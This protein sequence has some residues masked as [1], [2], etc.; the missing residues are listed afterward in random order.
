MPASNGVLHSTRWNS[1]PLDTI[2]CMP[3]VWP[4]AY[5]PWRVRSRLDLDR[6]RFSPDG[7]QRV[8]P[9][10][11]QSEFATAKFTA[12]KTYSGRDAKAALVL[13][14][15]NKTNPTALIGKAVEMLRTH[16]Q[17]VSDDATA[18]TNA[19]HNFIMSHPGDPDIRLALAF[20]PVVLTSSASQQF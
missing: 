12:E 9:R 7:Q 11:L 1:S 10:T 20:V 13:L 16:P 4:S 17:Y 19:R 15:K 6:Q 18:A 5:A 3:R 8:A 2:E 14:V